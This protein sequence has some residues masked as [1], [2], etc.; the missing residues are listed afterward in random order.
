V[1]A[2]GAAGPVKGTVIGVLAKTSHIDF[3]I[4]P[5]STAPA[6]ISAYARKFFYKSSK[7]AR[8]NCD[9]PNKYNSAANHLMVGVEFISVD[10]F[11]RKLEWDVS[12]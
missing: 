6:M 8:N 2:V 7:N 10:Y 1:G 3:A 5:T 12:I 4:V 11:R 9:F